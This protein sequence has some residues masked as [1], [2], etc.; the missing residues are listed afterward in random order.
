MDKVSIRDLVLFEWCETV[1]CRAERAVVLVVLVV[2]C[3]VLVLGVVGIGKSR[4]IDAL[5]VELVVLGC[6]VVYVW[7]M[8]LLR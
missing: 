1:G 3:G 2:G 4:F 6:D 8:F 7:V 5:V